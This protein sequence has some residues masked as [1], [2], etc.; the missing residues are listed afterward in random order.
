MSAARPYK[1]LTQKIVAQWEQ[2]L[3]VAR[4]LKLD[5]RIEV[6]QLEDFAAL[7]EHAKCAMPPLPAVARS[8]PLVLYFE[9]QADA[10]ELEAAVREI[11]PNLQ[12][13]RL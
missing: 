5:M 6:N 4:E 11:K 7:I 3:K 8:H 12:T 10:D 2:R 9:T 1:P 13:V